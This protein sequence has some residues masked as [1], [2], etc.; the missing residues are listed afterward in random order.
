MGDTTIGSLLKSMC[1]PADARVGTGEILLS[2]FCCVQLLCN[3]G[4]MSACSLL[5]DDVLCSSLLQLFL[6]SSSL[7]SSCVEILCSDCSVEFLHNSLQ[8]VLDYSVLSSLLSSNF[9]SLFCGFDVS[10]VYPHY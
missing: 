7:L 5:G 10:H 9:Y 3:L 4:N 8:I 2:C 1:T 6:G